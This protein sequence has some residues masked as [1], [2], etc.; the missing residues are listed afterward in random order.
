MGKKIPY[1]LG[2]LLGLFTSSLLLFI[3]FIFIWQLGVFNMGKP[4]IYLYPTEPMDVSVKLITD[5]KITVSD[6]PYA[7]GWRVSATSSGKID[8]KYDYLFYEADVGREADLSKGWIVERESI[9]EWFD[10]M[11]PEFGLNAKEKKDFMDYWMVN[12][13]KS[14]YYKIV[15][16]S[17]EDLDKM[18][19]LDVS[20]K[21]ETII[22]IGRAH[23]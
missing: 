20:P 3:P 22:Q 18:V 6:P 5:G 12:L 21:P 8:G 14:P 15:I 16:L 11:L 17:N 1:Y 4:V 7:G 23:V 19:K 10:T 13:P 2:F 9:G